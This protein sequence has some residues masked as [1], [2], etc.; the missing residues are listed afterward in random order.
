MST[1]TI[2]S[3]AGPMS[4]TRAERELNK[5]RRLQELN[6]RLEHSLSMPIIPVSAAARDLVKFCTSTPDPLL[7]SVWGEFSK[8]RPY[9][10]NPTASEQGCCAIL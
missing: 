10:S 1:A 9:T 4:S 2:G 3:A 6:L 5:L 8:D 7:P